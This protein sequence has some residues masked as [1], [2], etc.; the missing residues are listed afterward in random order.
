MLVHTLQLRLQG[1][2]E[3]RGGDLKAA[4]EAYSKGLELGSPRGSHL[5]HANRSGVRLSR[6]NAQGALED[7]QAA[8]QLAP[9]GFTTA[10]IR[11]VGHLAI[12]TVLPC[13]SFSALSFLATAPALLSLWHP[14]TS[15]GWLCL[16]ISF[17]QVVLPRNSL[18]AAFIT[19]H[20][21]STEANLVC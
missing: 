21:R 6:G 12:C 13:N 16:L 14:C 10:H 17:P 15:Q 8:V 9:A 18:N 3:A 19:V 20:V 5:L 4:E 11:L 2:A 7:A 1:N